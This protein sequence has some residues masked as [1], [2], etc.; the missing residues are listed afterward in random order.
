L[1]R[2]IYKNRGGK[3]LEGFPVVI[4]AEDILKA[5][6]IF[7]KQTGI[8]PVKSPWVGCSVEFNIQKSLDKL[9]ECDT[10][11]STV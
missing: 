6:E 1:K 8:D 5:D 7:K 9:N 11:R 10:F 2:F 3:P 4:D